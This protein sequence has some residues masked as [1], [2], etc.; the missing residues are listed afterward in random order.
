[1]FFKYTFNEANLNKIIAEIAIENKRSLS[2]AE[3]A[4][5]IYEGT[6][7]QQGYVDGKYVDV[8]CFRLLREEWIKK[9]E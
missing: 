5:F 3:K 4:G 6:L 7:K 1:M 2:A 9:K 8:K